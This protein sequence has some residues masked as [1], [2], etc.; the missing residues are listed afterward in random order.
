MGILHIYRIHIQVEMSNSYLIQIQRIWIWVRLSDTQR[1]PE[2]KCLG[3]CLRFPSPTARSRM[4][5]DG[6]TGLPPAAHGN[7]R[8]RARV[9]DS[10]HRRSILAGFVCYFS[11]PFVVSW[12]KSSCGRARPD[13]VGFRFV[14]LFFFFYLLYFLFPLG[15][16]WY[17]AREQ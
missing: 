11:S 17:G 6:P 1:Q 8:S 2:K 15:C 16:M 14:F 10:H 5:I 3:R 7:I 13:S 4:C 9:C 12:P